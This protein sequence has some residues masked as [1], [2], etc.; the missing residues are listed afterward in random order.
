MTGKQ[1]PWEH[2]SA[3]GRRAPKV[4]SGSDGSDRSLDPSPALKFEITVSGVFVFPPPL[5]PTPEPL[6]NIGLLS[7]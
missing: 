2:S 3:G 4:Q 7:L 5:L 6:G 1:K